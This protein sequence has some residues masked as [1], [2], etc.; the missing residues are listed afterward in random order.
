MEVYNIVK[1][2]TEQK[3]EIEHILECW[4]AWYRDVAVVKSIRSE[5][6]YYKDYQQ[7]LLDMSYKLT[8]NKV[9]QN[10]EFIKTAILDIK[11]NIYST[12][13]IENLLLKLKER[14]K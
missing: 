6:L 5:D 14:K 3:E 1:E 13:V 11:Q 2:I 4:L 8:Y 7:Q 12:F 10:I 9:S